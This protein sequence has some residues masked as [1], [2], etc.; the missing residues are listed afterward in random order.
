LAWFLDR[1]GI[2]GGDGEERRQGEVD[3][4]DT[5]IHREHRDIRS[6]ELLRMLQSQIQEFS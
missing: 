4:E 2:D 1:E 3:A 6:G 5:E